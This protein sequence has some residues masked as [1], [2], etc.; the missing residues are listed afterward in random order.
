M[1]VEWNGGFDLYMIAFLEHSGWEIGELVDM[2]MCND[3]DL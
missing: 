1:G 3:M 2:C